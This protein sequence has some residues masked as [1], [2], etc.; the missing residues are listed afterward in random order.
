MP[1]LRNA[2]RARDSR[3]QG[4][5]LPRVDVKNKWLALFSIDAIQQ[6][7]C[8]LPRIEAKITAAA[9]GNVEPGNSQHCGSQTH[10][11]HAQH[12]EN[13]RGHARGGMTTM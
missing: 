12:A 10:T 2:G 8:Q 4:V 5:H 6:S 13:K 11:T 1:E 3:L 7:A 9:N